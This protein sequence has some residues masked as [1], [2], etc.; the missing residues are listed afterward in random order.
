[1]LVKRR[2]FDSVGC[3]RS[4]GIR[5]V[6][7]APAFADVDRAVRFGAAGP[8]RATRFGGLD[9]RSIFGEI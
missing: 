1:M 8:A 9:N 5:E 2:E 4:A 6:Y 3:G 7:M